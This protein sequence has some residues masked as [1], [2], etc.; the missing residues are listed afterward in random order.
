MTEREKL[1]ELRKRYPVYS[2]YVNRIFNI[3]QYSAIK[4]IDEYRIVKYN[5]ITI[6][7][8]EAKLNGGL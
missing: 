3:K 5:D 4:I 7:G 8:L 1:Q 6:E 2:I